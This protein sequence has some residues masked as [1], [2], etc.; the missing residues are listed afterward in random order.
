MMT[1]I[2]TFPPFVRRKL[3][4]LRVLFVVEGAERG[5]VLMEIL[6]VGLIVFVMVHLRH[7]F[8]LG[9]GVVIR[10]NPNLYRLLLIVVSLYFIVIFVGIYQTQQN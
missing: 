3:R 7:L 2:N 10:A 4:G 9:L 5:L 6:F 8:H 1:C